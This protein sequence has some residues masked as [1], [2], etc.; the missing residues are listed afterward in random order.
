MI[1]IPVRCSRGH[2]IEFT[3]TVLQSQSCIRT[4]QPTTKRVRSE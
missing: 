2:C 1:M 4:A 3:Q